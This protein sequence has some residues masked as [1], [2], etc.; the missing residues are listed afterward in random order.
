MAVTDKVDTLNELLRGEIAAL[1]GVSL[2][3]PDH[4][5]FSRRSESSA[6]ATPPLVRSDSTPVCGSLRAST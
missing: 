2:A 1:L 6:S 3:V 5:T 4:T